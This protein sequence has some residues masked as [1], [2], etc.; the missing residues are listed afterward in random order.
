MALFFSLSPDLKSKWKFPPNDT[1]IWFI[2]VFINTIFIIFKHIGIYIFLFI[3]ATKA[4]DIIILILQIRRLRWRAP[5]L[6]AQS[7]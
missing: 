7:C 1:I 5:H 3:I 4:I 2:K 6:R